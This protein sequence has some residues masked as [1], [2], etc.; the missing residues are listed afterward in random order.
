MVS[1]GPQWAFHSRFNHQPV[2]HM[3]AKVQVL[4][5]GDRND[6]GVDDVTIL[7]QC[8]KSGKSTEWSALKDTKKGSRALIYVE[9]PVCAVV[10]TADVLCDTFSSEY[11]FRT[12]LG[13]VRMLPKPVDR[14]KLQKMFPTWGWPKATRNATYVPAHL[15]TTVWTTLVGKFLET[16]TA[17]IGT[18]QLPGGGFGDPNSNKEVEHAAIKEAKRILIADG[19]AV[20]SR[21]PEKIGYDLDASKGELVLHVEVKGVSGTTLQFPITQGEVKRA[22]TDPSF[23]LIAVTNALSKP[24]VVS[25]DGKQLLTKFSLTPLQYMATFKT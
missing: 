25:F 8:A 21:E 14:Y 11:G 12:R 22:S 5:G 20:K 23:R 2:P 4:F 9:A 15:E 3:N 10:A 18:E 6:D 16:G 24:V 7:K 13:N 17:S 19:F 1:G